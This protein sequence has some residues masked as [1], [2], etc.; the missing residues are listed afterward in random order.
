MTAF[1]ADPEAQSV[2]LLSTCWIFKI[3]WSLQT[4]DVSFWKRQNLQVLSSRPGTALS[5]AAQSFLRRILVHLERVERSHDNGMEDSH[6]DNTF[7]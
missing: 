2:L 5:A 6:A 7:C 3:R 1:T 4:L